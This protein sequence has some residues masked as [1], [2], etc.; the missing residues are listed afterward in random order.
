ML[1]GINKPHL[2]EIVQPLLWR[3]H[4]VYNGDSATQLFILSSYVGI[5]SVFPSFCKLSLHNGQG[6][7]GT[8][9]IKT[10]RYNTGTDPLAQCPL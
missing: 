4:K 1:K 10:E 8:Q 2:S 7:H 5:L 9:H 3:I 6:Y